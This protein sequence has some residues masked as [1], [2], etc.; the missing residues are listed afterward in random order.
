MTAFV[1]G[2]AVT[3]VAL[4]LAGWAVAGPPKSWPATLVLAI[5]GGGGVVIRETE[6]ADRVRISFISIILVAAAAIVGPV[7]AGLVGAIAM[8]VKPGR[9]RLIARLFNIAMMSSLGSVGGLIYM[10]V[11]GDTEF[12]SASPSH[13]LLQVGA[14]LIVTDVVQCLLNALLIATILQLSIGSPMRASIARL[15]TASG[16]AYVGYGVIG[17]LLVVLW[18]PAKV[19]WFASVLVLA[20]LLVARWAFDQY[21]EEVNA[22]E[23]TLRALVTAEEKKEPHNAGHS[24]RVA[25]LSE[26][27]AQTL[28]LGHKEIQD[29]RTAGMLHDIGTVAVPSRLLRGRHVLT[30]EDLVEIGAHARAGVQVVQGIEFLRGSLEGIAHHHERYDGR[31]YPGGLAGED[32]PLSARIVAVADT[33]DALTRPRTYRDALPPEQALAVIGDRAGTHFDPVVCEA[34]TRALARHEWPAVAEPSLDAGSV[35]D[36]DEP[37]ISDRLAARPD[38]RAKI[39]GAPSPATTPVG[40]RTRAVPGQG[41]VVS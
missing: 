28:G 4:L 7:G 17:F 26:W 36:H 37:E 40:D 38:L 20:P 5:V 14:P 33:F 6:V 35:I 16:M 12:S 18:L 32:I 41:A 2:L 30:D 19:G 10:A 3:A 21:G 34:L 9:S 31:G 15:L 22:H 24:D 11:G 23:R 25:Q 8:S 27:I 39:D 29:I 13:V 1:G